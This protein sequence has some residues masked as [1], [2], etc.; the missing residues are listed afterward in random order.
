[1][2]SLKHHLRRVLGDATLTFEEISTLLAQVEVCL[3][4][5]LLQALS[6][7]PDD[8]AALTPSHFLVGSLLTV[9]P[10]PSML[11]SPENCLTRWLLQQMRDHFWEQWSREY[12]HYLVHRP[13]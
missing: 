3:S 6:D 10:E 12:L 7:D 11:E 1:M 2:K 13:K 8:I 4:L 5:Q 9:V